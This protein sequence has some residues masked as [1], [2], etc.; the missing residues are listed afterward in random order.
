MD[1]SIDFDLLVLLCICLEKTF[2]YVRITDTGKGISQEILPN[3][4][5]PFFTTKPPGEG[6]GL[7]LDIVK[8]IV[9]KHQGSIDVESVPGQTSF[10]VAIPIILKEEKNV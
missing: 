1:W 6:S 7:G 4:F 2:L 10:T 5:Q 3:I 9:D 8:T